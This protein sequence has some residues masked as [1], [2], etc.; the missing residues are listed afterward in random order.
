M[1]PSLAALAAVVGTLPLAALAA[2]MAGSVRAR[3]RGNVRSA[4]TGVGGLGE[5][6]EWRQ[7]LRC[8]NHVRVN[9]LASSPALSF[10]P[11]P[12]PPQCSPSSLI[13]ARSL[14]SSSRSRLF[15]IS[16]S[17]EISAG[18]FEN[19]CDRVQAGRFGG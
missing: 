6:T 10:T 14:S 15:S 16:S 19:G 2:A 12:A 3:S 4:G 13:L 7:V 11:V 9:V 18:C 1:T 8:L 5:H 17:G